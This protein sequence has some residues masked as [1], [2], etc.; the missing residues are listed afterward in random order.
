M[1]VV[2]LIIIISS[3]RVVVVVVVVVGGGVMN[4][5]GVVVVVTGIALI[6]LAINIS[7]HRQST[8]TQMNNKN[9]YVPL[10][11]VA[12][13]NNQHPPTSTYPPTYLIPSFSSLCAA[14]IPAQLLHTIDIPP[15]TLT[16]HPPP[17]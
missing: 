8:V 17:L 7:P 10:Y 3:S 4:G 13:N 16:T 1:V 15:T 5:G 12:T 6:L 9:L 11:E 14:H 2:K